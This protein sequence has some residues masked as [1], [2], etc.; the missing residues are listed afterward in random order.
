MAGCYEAVFEDPSLVEA[1]GKCQL[2]FATVVT[3]LS[4]FPCMGTTSFKYL[5]LIYKWYILGGGGHN[6]KEIVQSYA[7]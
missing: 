6:R 7:F 3:F 4:R 1:V 2:C 5:V